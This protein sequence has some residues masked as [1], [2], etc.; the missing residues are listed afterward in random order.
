[1]VDSEYG[2]LVEN[3]VKRSAERLRRR[4][5]AAEGL[6]Q[7]YAR[8]SGATRLAES[9]DHSR[10]HTGRNGEK[11]QR[12]RR[13]VEFLAQRGMG[14]RSTVIATDVM[15]PLLEFRADRLVEAVLFLDARK[16]TRPKLLDRP[17]RPRD[18]DDGHL[19]M[20]PPFHRIQGGENLLVYEVARGPEEDERIRVGKVHASLLISQVSPHGRRTNGLTRGAA[21]YEDNLFHFN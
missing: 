20:A 11:V 19:E 8:A 12:V 18:P 21:G 10:K 15:E 4:E 1:M 5:I 3:S 9:L 7:N 2:R 14:G 17:I 6:F 13:L 16:G